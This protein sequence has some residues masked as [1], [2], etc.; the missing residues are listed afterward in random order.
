[1]TTPAP[2]KFDLTT[3][4]K[5]IVGFASA[6]GLSEGTLV[7]ALNGTGITPSPG[8]HAL[9]VVGSVVAGFLVWWKSNAP[10]RDKIITIIEQ[11]LEAQA[12]ARAAQVPVAPPI[13]PVVPPVP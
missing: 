5:S 4:S 7:T 1:M 13:A 3:I 9:I 8:I 12:Q 6:L 10:E 11:Y 2:A